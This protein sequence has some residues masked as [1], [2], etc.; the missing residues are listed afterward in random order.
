MQAMRW[1]A[2]VC[3]AAGCG[4]V[5]A[6]QL[7]PGRHMGKRPREPPDWIPCGPARVAAGL[8]RFA[9]NCRY[10]CCV[11]NK[12]ESDDDDDDDY[13]DPEP[14]APAVS[15]AAAAEAARISLVSPGPGLGRA[16]ECKH[17]KTFET[18]TQMYPLHHPK[19]STHDEV[20]EKL[21]LMEKYEIALQ[22][23]DWADKDE[24]M[25]NTEALSYAKAAASVMAMT[26]SLTDLCR[27]GRAEARQELQKEPAIGDFRSGQIYDLAQTGTCQALSAFENNKIPVGSDGLP[28]P[29]G[30]GGRSMEGAKDKRKLSK[31]LGVSVTRAAEMW[32]GV[33][34]GL[35][36]IKNIDELRALSTTDAARLHGPADAGRLEDARGKADAGRSSDA[37]LSLDAG[38]SS[39][40]NAADADDNAADADADAGWLAAADGAS[41][42]T[43]SGPSRSD[44]TFGLARHE[45]LQEPIPAEEAEE[46][47]AKV[48]RIVREQQGCAGCACAC[49]RPFASRPTPRPRD[50]ML[51]LEGPAVPPSQPNDDSSAEDT[52]GGCCRGC[53]CCWHVDFVGGAP[54]RGYA[55]HDVDLLIWHRHKPSSW[56]R[57]RDKCV[58]GPLIEELEYACMAGD[59]GLISQKDGWQMPKLCHSKREVVGGVRAH[60]LDV[61]CTQGTSHGFENLSQD[62]HDKVFGVWRTSIEQGE[63]HRRI[64]LIVCS[65][66]EE[67]ALCRLTWIGSRLLNRMMRLHAIHNGLFLSAHAMLVTDQKRPLHLKDHETGEVIRLPAAEGDPVPVPVPYKYLRTER[68]ILFLLGGCT[69]AFFGI[70]DPRQRNA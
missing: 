47:R 69:E 54:R 40:N 56:G 3:G 22:G 25:T 17:D 41:V 8:P 9:S 5:A 11:P 24:R 68:D 70:L 15:T 35:P 26:R 27:R 53:D 21:R 18:L 10:S 65:F 20:A 59:G 38:R 67:L 16:L 66:P 60:R 1:R 39:D 33:Y 19:D 14:T 50:T 48:L 44:F 62:H 23:D 49:T 37:R 2:A 32:E 43:A 55:G 45:E 34:R 52:H 7:W 6:L 42:S 58:L 4:G 36:K 28:R 46:M 57:E 12:A 30:I 29:R 51:C 61:Q 31:V 64:D 63:R 13:N